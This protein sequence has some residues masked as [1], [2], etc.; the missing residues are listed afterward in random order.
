MAQARLER[1]RASSRLAAAAGALTAHVHTTSYNLIS[2]ITAPVTFCAL[3]TN[4]FKNDEFAE[5]KLYKLMKNYSIELFTEAP[6]HVCNRLFGGWNLRIVGESRIGK[7]GK[8][9][10]LASGNLTHLTKHNASVV[11][12]RFSVRPLCHSG[13]VRKHGSP[14]PI[15]HKSH[16]NRKVLD[17]FARVPVG[18]AKLAH[19]L[20]VYQ[21]ASKFVQQFQLPEEE[22]A[23]WDTSRMES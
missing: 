4:V 15:H 23:L 1:A 21:F 18:Q 7:I 10:N 20:S 16:S 8:E 12:R 6:P 13:P 11:S 22:L 14:T 5:I 2:H 17:G 9:I 3:P 19:T